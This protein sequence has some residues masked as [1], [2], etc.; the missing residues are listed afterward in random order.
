MSEVRSGKSG[1]HSK[2]LGKVK[3]RSTGLKHAAPT[4]EALRALREL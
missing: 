2:K 3:K 4:K 1:K